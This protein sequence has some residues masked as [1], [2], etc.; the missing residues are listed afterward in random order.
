MASTLTDVARETTSGRLLT[1][2]A[3]RQELATM[4]SELGNTLPPGV[5]PERFINVALTAVQQT[6]KLLECAPESLFNACKKAALD[7]LLPDGREGAIV[8]RWNSKAKRLEATWQPMVQGIYAKAKRRGSVA[9]LVA[10]IVYEG[11]PFEVLMGDEDRIIHRRDINLVKKGNEIAVYA[12][13]TLKDGTKERETMTW[14]Q[15]MDVRKSSSDPTGPAWAQWTD[16]M[17]KK[18]CIRRLSKRLPA[19]DDGDDELKQAIERVDE[20]YPFGKNTP[21]PATTIESRA[22]PLTGSE[23]VTVSSRAPEKRKTVKELLTEVE[24]LFAAAQSLG[25]IEALE[26]REDVSKL[27]STE[28]VGKEAHTQLHQYSAA[29]RARIAAVSPAETQEPEFDGE[30]PDV[31]IPGEEYTRA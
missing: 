8:P 19:L 29:A 2:P 13:A 21:K 7:G 9:N 25:G 1:L 10:N 11:E 14:E 15:V 18:S 26:S 20:L 16:E 12:I 23:P 24:P 5:K 30:L 6:P 28:F 31:H 4:T 22:E 3:V 17:A 27:M